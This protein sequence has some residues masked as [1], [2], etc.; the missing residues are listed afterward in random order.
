MEAIGLTAPTNLF[1]SQTSA[2]Q[3]IGQ[4]AGLVKTFGMKVTI[5]ELIGAGDLADKLAYA[6]ALYAAYYLGGSI[7][8]LAVAA[9][10]FYACKAGPLAAARMHQALFA[11]GIA[12]IQPM[13][14]FLAQHPEVFDVSSPQRAFYGM[15]A[16][17][18]MGV[19]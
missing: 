11:Q 18:G 9:D 8:S 12:L 10:A 5:R 6:E 7:E 13:H 2:L 15:H 17:T 19:K 1:S 16:R 3:T 14:V 4:L